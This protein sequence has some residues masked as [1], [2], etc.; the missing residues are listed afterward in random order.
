MAMRV[1]RSAWTLSLLQKNEFG[2]L[3][4]PFMQELP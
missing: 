4:K 3:L 2:T 1:T